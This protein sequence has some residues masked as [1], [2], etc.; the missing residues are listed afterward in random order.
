VTPEEQLMRTVIEAW[1]E[2]D[3]GPVREALDENVVWKS[4]SS[5]DVG[6]FRFGGIYRGRANVLTLLSTLSTSYFFRRYSAKE[7]ISNG[8]VVWGL[9][10][11]EG[12]YLPPGARESERKPIHFETAFRWRIRKGKIL[13]AQS[14]F[15]TAA[16]LFQQRELPVG[17]T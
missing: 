5:C 6:T 3:V 16:L 1:G 17:V 2:A 9:F 15:D 11:V 14:F 10:D 12:T 13:E 4:A 7:I 8:E